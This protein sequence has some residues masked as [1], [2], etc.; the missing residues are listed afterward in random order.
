MEKTTTK[1]YI[2][3]HMSVEHWEKNSDITYLLLD[4]YKTKKIHKIRKRMGY[5]SVKLK[6]T[7]AK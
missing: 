3:I 2:E 6:T 4:I 7:L 5:E 1:Y